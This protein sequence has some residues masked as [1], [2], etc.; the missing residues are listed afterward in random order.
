MYIYVYIYSEEVFELF[1]MFLFC[2]LCTFL[3]YLRAAM[4]GA[5]AA[6]LSKSSADSTP[7][8]L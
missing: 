8:R 5:S 1:Y 3:I 7:C 2:C 6:L 4:A